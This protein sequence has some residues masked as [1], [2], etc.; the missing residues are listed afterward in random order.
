MK[1]NKTLTTEAILEHSSIETLQQHIL[2]KE[3]S[4]IS[5]KSFFNQVQYVTQKFNLNFV[6]SK[7]DVPKIVE[8]I[9]TRNIHVHNRGIINTIYLSNFNLSEFYVDDYRKI[10]NDY[11]KSSRNTLNAFIVQFL[12]LTKQKIT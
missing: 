9:E 4:E 2:N 3:L 5:Y 12:N 10:D 1:S 8:I 7:D 6:G 11:L